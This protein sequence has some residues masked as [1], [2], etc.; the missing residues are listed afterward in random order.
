MVARLAAMASSGTGPTAAPLGARAGCKHLGPP[1][2]VIGQSEA[3][4]SYKSHGRVAAAARGCRLAPR[5][6][7]FC[8]VLASPWPA[9]V[10]C[11]SYISLPQL[12]VSAEPQAWVRNMHA[13]MR[14]HTGLQIQCIAKAIAV[15]FG[16]LKAAAGLATGLALLALRRAARTAP[17]AARALA[18]AGNWQA[19]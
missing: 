14:A 3:K 9:D 10:L 2:F 16:V 7:D 8:R 4:M 1:C 19:L 5:D 13:W 11:R 12:C 17:L 15:P 18:S 6:R